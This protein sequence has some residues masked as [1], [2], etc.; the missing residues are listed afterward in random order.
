MSQ[1]E[2]GG[3][4]PPSPGAARYHRAE[5]YFGEFR[6]VV[7]LPWEA[8]ESTIEALYRDGMLEIQ[9][10]VPRPIVTQRIRV[11]EKAR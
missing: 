3:P 2:L 5:I 8:E 7:E 11:R 9:L 1:L 10:K 4:P 6:R